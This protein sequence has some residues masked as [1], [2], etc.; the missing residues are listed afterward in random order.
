MSQME[1][2]NDEQN[3]FDLTSKSNTN[4]TLGLSQLDYSK[5]NPKK[6]GNEMS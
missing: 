4:K 1:S 2:A 6:R 3:V 5:I